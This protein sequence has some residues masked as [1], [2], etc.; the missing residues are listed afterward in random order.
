M[1]SCL[2]RVEVGAIEQVQGREG[3]MHVR[4]RDFIHNPFSHFDGKVAPGHVQFLEL[5]YLS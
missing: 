4:L 2:V 5:A 3:I 1:L